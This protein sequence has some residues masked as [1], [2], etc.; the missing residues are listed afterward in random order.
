MAVSVGSLF[1]IVYQTYLTRQA[2]HASVLP[3][4]YFSLSAN[5]EG[6]ATRVSNSGIGRAPFT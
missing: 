5:E 1:I 2:Q 6:V 3:Y 4:L